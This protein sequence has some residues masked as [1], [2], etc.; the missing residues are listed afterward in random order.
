[1]STVLRRQLPI[2]AEPAGGGVHFRVWAPRRKRVEVVLGDSQSVALAREPNGYFSGFVEEAHSGM[3]YRFRLDYGERLVPDPASRYQPEGPHGPSQ[4]ADPSSHTWNDS[5][6]QGVRI[7]GQVIYEMHIGTF[8]PEGTWSAAR[9]LLPELADTGI[10]LLEIMPVAE[11]PG[12]FGW[13]YDGVDCFAPAHLYGTPDDFRAF[14]DRSH[15]LGLG[16]ILD[17][18]YNHFGPDGCYLREFSADYFTTRHDNE[19]GEAV[20]FDGTNSGPVREFITSNAEYWIEEFHLD[21]LRL[22]ATQ[23]MFDDSPDHIVAAIARSARRAA[24]NRAIVV[25]AENEPQKAALVRRPENDGYGLDALWND[26]FHHTTRV[27]LTG[28]TEAYYSDYRGTPQEIISAVKWGFLYQGQFYQW[29][30]NQRGSYSFDLDPAAFVNYIENHDQLANS[31][32]GSRQRGLTSL[33][34][35]KAITAV[36]LL[37]PQTPLLFQGQEYGASTPFLYFA[38]HNPELACMVRRGRSDFLSQFP[39]IGEGRTQFAMGNPQDRRTFEEC[40]LDPREREKNTH[41]LELHR[42]LLRLRRQDEVFRAQRSDWIH[43]AVLGPEAFALRFFGESHGDRLILVN[44]GRTVTLRPN[45]EP[46]L[47]PPRS[48]RWELMWCSEDPKYRGSGCP[49]IRTAGTWSIQ[50]HSAMVMY[51]RRT[52]D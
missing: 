37:A 22:D 23:Q 52:G 12:A 10:T 4:I 5:A 50:G 16:V 41:I 43:G 42:D 49:P 47:G 30:R 26:D 36:L 13:G 24:G 7:S 34:R 3:R 39:S 48:G 35:Y 18:V 45:P 44:L 38:D 11:F 1:M 6:W 33:G 19:W 21:G 40:K 20:N 32:Y 46:L 51:E 17:V 14:V 28:N 9:E 25:I 27:A 2:G 15:A 31:A 8:T 29:Q